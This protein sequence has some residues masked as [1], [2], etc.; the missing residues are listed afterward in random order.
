MK[1]IAVFPGSF[2]PITKG[3]EDLIL[4]GTAL[5]DEV[6]VALGTNTTKNYMFSVEQRLQWITQVFQSV[7]SIRVVS[8]SGLTVDFCKNENAQFILRG[9]RNTIDM[10]YEKSIAQMN[11]TIAPEIESVLLYATPACA[12]VN[13]TTVRELIKNK[14]DVSAFLPQGV[15]VYL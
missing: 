8:Y 2:D 4:R 13:S 7:P 15:N 9:I 10:E 14:A 6:I 1:R 11:K 3:H 5:F 12:A